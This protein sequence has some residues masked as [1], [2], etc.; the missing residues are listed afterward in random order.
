MDSAEQVQHLE[1]GLPQLSHRAAEVPGEQYRYTL[2]G[3][4]A[5][6]RLG[7]LWQAFYSG[8]LIGFVE[9]YDDLLKDEP[10]LVPVTFHGNRA[11]YLSSDEI[12]RGSRTRALS[13]LAGSPL[14]SG[15]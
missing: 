14:A 1:H 13:S 9:R 11:C 8:T 7:E 4:D 12:D 3:T 5:E 6:A 2:K 10:C 15:R